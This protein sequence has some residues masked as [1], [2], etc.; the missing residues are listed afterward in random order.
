MAIL[1]GQFADSHSIDFL[2]SVST[3]GIKA[4]LAYG[5][6]GQGEIHVNNY[7]TYSR[8]NYAK[9]KDYRTGAKAV[10]TSYV[11]TYHVDDILFLAGGGINGTQVMGFV[12][13]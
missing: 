4:G 11:T 1:C 12:M 13:G 9:A 8:I 2:G 10:A 7:G 5:N 3:R 6:G